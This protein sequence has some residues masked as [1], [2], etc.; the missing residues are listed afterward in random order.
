MPKPLPEVLSQHLHSLQAALLQQHAADLS[1]LRRSPSLSFQGK[2]A[3]S[4]DNSGSRCLRCRGVG[5]GIVAWR[6]S[7]IRPALPARFVF[8]HLTVDFMPPTPTKSSAFLPRR[9]AR[10]TDCQVAA[11]ARLD[12]D[13]AP[14]RDKCCLYCHWTL[15]GGAQQC[16]AHPTAESGGVTC[17]SHA[18]CRICL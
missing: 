6:G 15:K 12:S 11:T 1:G 16:C 13:A 9:S 5:F 2:K 8:P 18:H 4:R 10:R 7:L 14:R 17:S 3:T